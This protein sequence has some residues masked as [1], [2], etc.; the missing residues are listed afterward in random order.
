M[1]N[2][3]SVLLPLLKKKAITA[4][5]GIQISHFTME[6]CRKHMLIP[7]RIEN[8][9]CVMDLNNMSLSAVPKKWILATMKSL[10][11][12]YKC[13]SFLTFVLNAST[14]F[15][16]LWAVISPFVDEK[17]KSAIIFSKN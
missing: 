15:R 11:S 4:E 10:A 5:D 13:I 16:F 7:D 2:R 8:V 3:P 17:I 1:H 14:A 6:Y 9:Q 12:N